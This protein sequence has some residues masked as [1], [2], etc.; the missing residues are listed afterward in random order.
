[1]QEARNKAISSKFLI[2]ML[3]AGTF[4]LIVAVNVYAATS[5]TLNM[6]INVASV[7]PSVGTPSDGGSTAATPTNVGTNVTFTTTGT[8]PNGDGYWLAICK[9]GGSIT[10]GASG[11]APTCTAGDWCISS[12]AVASGNPN[13]CTY[14]AQQA[15]PMSNAWEAYACD[16]DTST[17]SC[18]DAASGDSPF[19]VNH[20]PIIGTVTIGPSYGSSASVDP[21]N[22]T[23]GIVYFRVGVTDP[24]SESPQDTIDMFACSAAGFNPV[25]GECTGGSLL[26]SVTGVTTGT[27]AECTDSDLAPIPTAHA[28]DGSA[29]DVKIYLRD[30]SSTKLQDAG[31]DNDQSYEV[32]DIAPTVA[33]YNVSENPLIPSA[34]GSVVQSFTATL[35]DNNGYADITSAFGAIYENTHGS[36]DGDG[37]C[38][39]DDELY[40]YDTAVCDLSG[41]SGA[42]VTVTCGGAGNAITTWF[43][44][45]PS[46]AWKAHVNA[47]TDLGISSLATEG[48]FTVNALNAVG[49][50]EASIPYGSLTT[51]ATSSAQTTTIQNAGNIITDALI[52]GDDMI[53]GVNS[54]GRAQQHWA[55]ISG[56]TWGTDDYTLLASASVGSAVNGCSDRT[57][58]VTTDYT[59]YTTSQIFWKL[60]IPTVQETGSYTG[61]SYFF[62]TPNDC[63][64]G[65]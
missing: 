20:P 16:D 7:T 30:N 43:N 40:C 12:S 28:L 65:I 2:A 57:I 48:T 53:S 1:M 41:G 13:S 22:D 46:A 44:I 4:G 56:F 9:T 26:C 33:G 31:T 29:N 10:P 25:T 38:N 21:G 63:S 37:A 61:T 17:S 39:P 54:I 45:A 18:S 3:I 62:A 58:A 47:V 35:T 55:P 49:V 34:G 50:A 64:G 24:D 36:L 14:Q 52:D 5:D 23:T 6:T 32:T 60:K 11:A 59:S 8:D 42:N 19:H 51:G 15:D 27:N